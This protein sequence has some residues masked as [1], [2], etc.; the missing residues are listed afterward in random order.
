MPDAKGIQV[1]RDSGCNAL[2]TKAEGG[3]NFSAQDLD[4]VVWNNE[5]SKH[6]G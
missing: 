6:L 2:K 1:P 4:E 3:G 5:A